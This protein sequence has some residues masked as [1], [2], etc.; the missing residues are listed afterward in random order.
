VITQQLYKDELK[1]RILKKYSRI[2]GVDSESARALIKKLDYHK[3]PFLLERIAQT[4]FDEALFNRNGSHREY[5][6]GRKLRYAERYI[7]K[8]YIINEDC[9]DVLWTL[10]KVRKLYKQFELA[11]YCFK[12]IIEL[13]RRKSINKSICSDPSLVPIKSNDSK[14]ELYRLYHDIAN[15]SISKRYLEAYKKG[16]AQGIFTLY[17]PLE[18]FLLD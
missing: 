8:A 14:F 15:K 6:E 3:D 16:V 17:K 10:G 1:N 4:Y 12:R 13:G 2:V 11:I 5:F 18:K 9:I 7:I